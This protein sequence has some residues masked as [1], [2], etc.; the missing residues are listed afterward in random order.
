MT[1]AP[2]FNFILSFSVESSVGNIACTERTPRNTFLHT[3]ID[4]SCSAVGKMKERINPESPAYCRTVIKLETPNATANGITAA[5]NLI[6]TF[7]S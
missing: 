4:C 1:S 3:L 2:V 7:S 5:N 6:K